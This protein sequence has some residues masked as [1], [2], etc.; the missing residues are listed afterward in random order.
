[1]ACPSGQSEAFRNFQARTKD[2]TSG[3]TPP[4]SHPRLN[5]T[6]R[7]CPC[8]LPSYTPPT[9]RCSLSSRRCRKC[10]GRIP[11]SRKTTG[12][13]ESSRERGN[14]GERAQLH[15]ERRP[16]IVPRAQHIRGAWNPDRHPTV[17]HPR[18]AVRPRT[19]EATGP[20][21]PRD[22][23]R[24]P[25]QSSAHGLTQRIIQA[26]EMREGPDEFSS[27]ATSESFD[28]AGTLIRSVC[29]TAIVQRVE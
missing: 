6:S 7:R 14:T 13:R 22:F 3:H 21:V 2:D 29:A 8:I 27:T 4:S 11:P 1:M 15:D 18:C 10:P 25:V 12:R 26:I 19:W 17:S 24:V 5:P 23:S 9:E 20:Y 16:A 28:T